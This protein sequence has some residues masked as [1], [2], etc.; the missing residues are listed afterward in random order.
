MLNRL[1]RSAVQAGA[2]EAADAVAVPFGF[3]TRVVALWRNGTARLNGN[4]LNRL[5]R[6]V[7]LA[8]AAVLILTGVAA[9]RELRQT[10]E[11]DDAGLNEY[12]IAD[13]A[14]QTEFSQ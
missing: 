12:A 6:R 3:D 9:V 7:A 10:N 1:L 13:N 2:E 11:L 4:G 8:S 5:L 14:I